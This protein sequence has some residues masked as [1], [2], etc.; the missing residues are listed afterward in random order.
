M[1]LKSIK[2]THFR[3]YR[4]ATVIPNDDAMTGLLAPPEAGRVAGEQ[5]PFRSCM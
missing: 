3:G 4:A 5:Q 2:L 1:R